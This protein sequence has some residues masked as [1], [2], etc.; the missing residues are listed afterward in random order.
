[1]NNTDTNT[2]NAENIFI[3]IMLGIELLN[4][5]IA[6]WSSYKLGHIVLNLEHVKCCCFEFDNVFLDI[7]DSES[8]NIHPRDNERHDCTKSH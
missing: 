6:V 7:S 2:D 3:Y 4:A 8:D 1:M 5:V